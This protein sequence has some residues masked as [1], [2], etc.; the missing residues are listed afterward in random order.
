MVEERF[1]AAFARGIDNDGGVGGRENRIKAGENRRGVTR[2]KRGIGDAVGFG[3]L[4]GETDRGLAEFDA[5]DAFKGGRSAEREKPAAA[6]R[7]DE[8]T[9]AS[10]S[11]ARAH[12]SGKRGQDKRVVLEK[13]A[14]QE[15]EF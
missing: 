4:T 6:I 11:G 2:L 9:G 10:S 7:V 8:K 5:R 1:V 15:A 3:V 13:I 12:V 14:G